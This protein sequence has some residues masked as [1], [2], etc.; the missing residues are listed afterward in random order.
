MLNSTT[1]ARAPWYAI[2]T[3]HTGF[4]RTAVAAILVAKLESQRLS[5]PR[6]EGKAAALLTFR[7][8]LEAPEEAA[9]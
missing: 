2:P 6:V 4:M 9:W 8:E 1:T 3:D 5:Y 7:D